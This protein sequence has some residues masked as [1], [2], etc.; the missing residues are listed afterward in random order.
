MPAH[1]TALARPS[2]LAR[3]RY[4]SRGALIRRVIIF[5]V[6][7]FADGLRDLFLSPISIAA[8][9]IGFLFG[10]RNPHAVYDRLME[11]GHESDRWIDLFGFHEK[12][13]RGPNLERVIGDIEDLVRE[14]HAR[15]GIT[16]EA[17]SRLRDLA[18]ELRRRASRR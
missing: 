15:G 4:N 6:K 7:L 10:G 18:A 17:E 9:A 16:A 5:Q 3:H 12:E 8:A 1:R 11:V 13:T 14:D 2:V